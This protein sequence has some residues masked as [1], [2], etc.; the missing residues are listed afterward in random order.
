MVETNCTVTSMTKPFN[1]PTPKRPTWSII[2]TQEWMHELIRQRS[3]QLFK[4]QWITSIEINIALL[5]LSLRNP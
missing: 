2:L 3:N 4:S 5:L 1:M